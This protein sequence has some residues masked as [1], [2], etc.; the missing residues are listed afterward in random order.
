[1]KRNEYSEGRCQN[2][3]KYCL[4]LESPFANK[5]AT[6]PGG[7]GG[8]AKSVKV[9]HCWVRYANRKEKKKK[10]KKKEEKEEK[11]EKTQLTA[12]L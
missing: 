5:T 6:C 9:T 7:S 3:S 11:E 1:L 4:P 2:S 10:K 8:R 12:K